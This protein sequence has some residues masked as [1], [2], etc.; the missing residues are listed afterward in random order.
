[1]IPDP[2]PPDTWVSG[3]DHGNPAW[4]GQKRPLRGTFPPR[5]HNG[6]SLEAK[7]RVILRRAQCMGLGPRSWNTAWPGAERA[8]SRPFGAACHKADRLEAK[9][10]VILLRV[11]IVTEA[12]RSW[13]RPVAD[14]SG[15]L[16]ILSIRAKPPDHLV[17]AAVS[18]ARRMVAM[19]AM[20][21]PAGVKGPTSRL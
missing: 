7:R 14:A 11:H 1:M 19:A 5:F 13:N 12:P 2:N 18:T 21:R 15:R 20:P 17:L 8:L 10:R 6:G 9:R 16:L 3:R 4:P